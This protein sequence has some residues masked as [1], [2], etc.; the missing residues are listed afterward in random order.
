M[1]GLVG[2]A[3]PQ[4]GAVLQ[5]CDRPAGDVPGV[6]VTSHDVGYPREQGGQTGGSPGGR[7]AVRL[8]T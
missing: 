1:P 4:R 7:T 3:L 2:D 5:G 6:P 8:P